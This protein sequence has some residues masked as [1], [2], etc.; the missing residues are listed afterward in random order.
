MPRKIQD[1]PQISKLPGSDEMVVP[2]FK[3]G[4]DYP[5]YKCSVQQISEKIIE[6][7][8]SNKSVELIKTDI[9]IMFKIKELIC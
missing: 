2:V 4:T 1:L 8:L 9:G 6:S 3:C 5:L 7:V